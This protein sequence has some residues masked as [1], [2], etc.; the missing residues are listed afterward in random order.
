MILEFTAS[1]VPTLFAF[2]LD[3]LVL[4]KMK[5]LIYEKVSRRNG[6]RKDTAAFSFALITSSYIKNLNPFVPCQ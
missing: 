2:L 3:Q 4:E 1:R 5:C 6:F